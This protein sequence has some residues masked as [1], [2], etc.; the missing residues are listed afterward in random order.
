MSIAVSVI[1][2]PSRGLRLVHAGL[3]C[4]VMAS[5]AACPGVV[6]PLLCLLAG[7][8]AWLRGRPPAIARQLDISG[9]GHMRLAVYQHNGGALRLLGGSTLWPRLLL[10]RLGDAAGRAALLTVLP[11]SVAPAH[12]R[13]LALACRAAARTE[14]NT[15]AV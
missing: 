10:L 1:V 8:L 7:A 15:P 14:I 6:A 11:D 5:A 9:V 3:C 2:R 12:W 13:P 4:C